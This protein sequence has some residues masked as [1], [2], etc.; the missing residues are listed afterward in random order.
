MAQVLLA[1]LAAGEAKFSD[2]LAI[3]EAAYTH[4]PTAFKMVY[5]TMQQ[6]KTKAVQKCFRLHNFKVSIKRKL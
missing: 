1:Q 3:I 2:V 4:T 6:L 5:S